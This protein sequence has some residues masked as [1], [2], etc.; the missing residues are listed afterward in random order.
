MIRDALGLSK[1][2]IEQRRGYVMAG[3]AKAIMEGEW[4]HLWRVKRGLAQEEDIG[5]KLLVN[6]GSYTEPFNL[7]YY[8]E[9]TGCELEYYT[10]NSH[11]IL[12]WHALH[13][14]NPAKDN[15]LHHDEFV[16]SKKYPHM[17]AH[18]DARGPIRKFNKIGPVDAK[19]VGQ[20]R[21][22][23]LTERYT[24]AMTHQAIVTGDDCWALS[25]FVG[26]GRYE[27]IEQEVDIF[28]RE[29]LIE[30]EMEFWGWVER[31]EEPMDAT[32]Q[33][34]PKPQPRL[35]SLDASATPVGSEDWQKLVARNNWLPDL[36][37]EVA[38]FAET[39][40]AHKAYS[41]AR[42]AINK[43]LPD[44]VGSI[45]LDVRGKMFSAK[46]ATTGTIT[47]KMGGHDA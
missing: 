32:P 15:F 7:A 3:D 38:V 43:L 29:E 30:K 9:Q 10:D 21:Y 16:A 42:T 22:D 37:N 12:S 14:R 40:G 25:V 6:M 34:P 24:W 31:N 41:A 4:N 27:I 23:E 46:R 33:A 20:F 39:E 13:G 19:H 18:L 2:A 36:Y 8:E 17:A 47:M 44:D 5:D 26:N 1:Y 28:A 11:C 35:R 45:F